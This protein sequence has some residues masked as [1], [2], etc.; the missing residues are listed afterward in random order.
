MTRV[1]MM[2]IVRGRLPEA[3]NQNL[4]D[5]ELRSMINQASRA[6]T[7]YT[8]QG[9]E[10]ASDLT[11]DADGCVAVPSTLI[12]LTRVEYNGNQIKK[13]S[14]AAIIDLEGVAD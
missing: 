9:E 3:V 11:V 5:A 13:T 7:I 2:T 14:M 1:E 4:G 8:R 12:R 10:T 6:L